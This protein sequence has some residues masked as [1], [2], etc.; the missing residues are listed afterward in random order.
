[1]QSSKGAAV[2]QSA[3]DMESFSPL[4][5]IG[6]I[7]AILTLLVTSART[8]MAAQEAAG[9]EAAQEAAGDEAVQE[10]TGGLYGSVRSLGMRPVTA[11]T[12]TLPELGKMAVT[13]AQGEYY[14]RDVPV[15][16]HAVEVEYLSLKYE[17]RASIKASRL[18]VKHYR[19]D[20]TLAEL[21]PL[22]VEA[23]AQVSLKMREFVSREA[24]NA[25]LYIDRDDIDRLRPMT[26]GDLLQ[27]ESGVDVNEGLD[28]RRF[29]IGRGPGACRPN[30]FVDGSPVEA[31]GVD[32][33]FPQHIEAVEVYKSFA[34]TPIQYR[35]S[36]R[37]GAILIWTREK[38][39][40]VGH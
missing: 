29:S 19:L 12:V 18:T 14:V 4:A 40:P 15:G 11:A 23:E 30:L 28:N 35:S 5:R 27:G 8:V 10:A 22:R 37:C 16:T 3:Y 1:V 21:E 20:L 38:L 2:T 17:T 34:L 33:F 6:L 9:D 13:N 26:T 39:A 24:R 32:D 7:T 31:F 25:G 36:N